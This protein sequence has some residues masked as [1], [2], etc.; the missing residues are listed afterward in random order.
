MTVMDAVPVLTGALRPRRWYHNRKILIAGGGLL[1]FAVLAIFGPL[2]APYDPYTMNTGDR[3]LPPG[4]MLE[5]GSLS[6]LGTDSLGR[7]MLS[8]VV[9][10]ARISLMVGLASV[11]FAILLG[12]SCGLLA[13]LC[14]GYVDGILMRIADIQLAFP[15][16][17]LAIFLSAFFEPSLTNVVIVLA[18]TRW[19]S[20][21]RV[22]RAIVLGTK[23][24][25]YVDSARVIG[26]A[27]LRILFTCHLPALIGPLLV[28][29]TA[30]MGLIIIAEASLS[31][32]GLGPPP[33]TP[34][35]GL[36]VAEGRQYLATAWW[37][38]AV[39]GSALALLVL[40]TG[41]LG[42]ALRE[43]SDPK[44]A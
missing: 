42:D 26:A 43:A 19:V 31:F 9:A 15:S 34:S 6:L 37:I 17:L 14:G 2:I 27:P 24:L 3:L 12:V 7:S 33:T 13:G 38:A 41:L 23:R 10:G 1:F 32:L 28:P 4:A 5:D 35:W 36:T 30:E 40:S 39:P 20:F 22:S 8:R 18:I 11:G 16:V 44:L 29:A 21:A 25:E